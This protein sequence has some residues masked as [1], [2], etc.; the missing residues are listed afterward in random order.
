MC[1]GR[2]NIAKVIKHSPCP[3][4]KEKCVNVNNCIFFKCKY[5]VDGETI[6]D[7]EIKYEKIVESD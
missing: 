1:F 7:K 6:D 4:C 5:V 2:F 3:L